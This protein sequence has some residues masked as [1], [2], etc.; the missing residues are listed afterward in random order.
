MMG[1]FAGAATACCAPVLAGAV[2]IAGVSSSWWAGAILGLFYLFGLV[3]PLLLSAA[4]I[5][6]FRGRLQDPRIAFSFAG[7]EIRMTLSRLVGGVAFIA[8]GI[9]VI[10]LALTGEAKTAP[11][12]QKAFGQWLSARASEVNAAVPAGVGWALMLAIA[13]GVSYLAVRSIHAP[14]PATSVSFASH[15]CC[16]T[17]ETTD[18]SE[19]EEGSEH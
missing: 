3:S 10:V 13:L 9:W 15:P 11:G 19:V 2:A 7:R 5:G 17:S 16:A 4:G 18:K 8:L 14:A 12:F 1:V 6:K